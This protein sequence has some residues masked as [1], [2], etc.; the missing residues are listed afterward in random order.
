MLNHQ[1]KALANHSTDLKIF[2]HAA[3]YRSMFGQ[4][5]IVHHKSG[6]TLQIY[7]VHSALM[8]ATMSSAASTVG[9][10]LLMPNPRR[11]GRS[12]TPPHVQLS[13]SPSSS[14]SVLFLSSRQGSVQREVHYAHA[15]SLTT[16][17]QSKA[18]FAHDALQFLHDLGSA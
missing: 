6:C 10:D 15:H 3:G 4:S 13:T 17:S 8:W 2:Y 11:L 1:G 5:A 18:C 12:A 14:D 16:L 9:Q 7:T